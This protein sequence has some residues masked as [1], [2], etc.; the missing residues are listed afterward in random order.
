MTARARQESAQQGGQG[1]PLWLAATACALVVAAAA[2]STLRLWHWPIE[3]VRVDE[4]LEHTDAE[5]LERELARHADTGFFALDLA[6]LKRR[7]EKLPWVR[8]ARLR[9]V[10]P[11]RLRLS[12]EEHVAAARW[13]GRALISDRGTVFAPSGAD[14]EGLPRLSGPEGEAAGML[15]RL[16]AMQ[17]QLGAIGPSIRGLHQDRRR[18]WRVE[19]DNG[20]TLRLGQ[21][22][23]DDR[24]ARFAAVW[25]ATLA[26]RSQAIEAVDLRYSGG[27]AV[28]WRDGPSSGQRTDQGA[29]DV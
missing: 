29:G 26:Q 19:L 1:V 3:I 18:S 2:V 8:A 5:R 11:N 12:I 9:R 7:V 24:L 13:N 20:V 21:R 6:A 25:P 17:S 16:H 15:E 22:A 23:L 4:P 10:W 27:V 28:A 14:I